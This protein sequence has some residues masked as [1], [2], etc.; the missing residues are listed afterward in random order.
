L[1][2]K[3]DLFGVIFEVGKLIGDILAASGEEITLPENVK[4]FQVF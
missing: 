2:S 1:T 4:V 3:K